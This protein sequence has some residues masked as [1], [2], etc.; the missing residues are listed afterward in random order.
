[1]AHRIRFAPLVLAVLMTGCASVSHVV[2]WPESTP[3]GTPTESAYVPDRGRDAATIAELRA[4]PAPE[5]PALVDGRNMQGDRSRLAAEGLVRVGA[6]RYSGTA[7]DVRDEALRQ[8]R[9]VGADRVLLYRLGSAADTAAGEWDTVYYVRFKLP[10]GAAFRDLKPE[11]RASLGRGGVEIGRVIGGTPA[12]RANLLAG[13]FVTALDGQPVSG[14]A[15]FQDMLRAHAGRSVT[16]TVV[17]HGETLK[18][19]VRLGVAPGD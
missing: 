15:G 13:D 1:M 3:T 18:R 10:F 16:L 19:A 8:G 9:E 6:A 14:K 11:E 5:Q 7:P 4:G 12:S 17:R 2:E